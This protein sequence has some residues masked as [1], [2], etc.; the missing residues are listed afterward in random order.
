MGWIFPVP[1]ASAV[2]ASTTNEVKC[3][4]GGL[5]LYLTSPPSGHSLTHLALIVYVKNLSASA[6]I[7]NLYI[8]N[9]L[10]GLMQR[11]IPDLVAKSLFTLT[12]FPFILLFCTH[13]KEIACLHSS[14]KLFLI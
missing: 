13:F 5:S 4:I 14:N 8:C 11:M 9:S 3:P 2:Y 12:F 6:Q 7:L 1:I 10:L